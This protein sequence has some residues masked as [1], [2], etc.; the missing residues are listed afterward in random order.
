MPSMIGTVNFRSY[1]YYQYIVVYASFKCFSFCPNFRVHRC[2]MFVYKIP[3]EIVK[4]H[5]KQWE[6]YV[7]NIYKNHSNLARASSNF[8]TTTLEGHPTYVSKIGLFSLFIKIFFRN[9]SWTAHR[10]IMSAKT[11][12][13]LMYKSLLRESEKI[14]SY[15]FR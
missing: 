12:V 1:Q 7:S 3:L 14:S 5:N 10:T 13:L 2:H 6:D 4:G 11:K 15:N 9:Q 8:L